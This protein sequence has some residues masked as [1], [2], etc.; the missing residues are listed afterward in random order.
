MIGY[1]V[2]ERFGCSWRM[3]HRCLLP[4]SSPHRCR[5]L[6]TSEA[7]QFVADS[8]A[9]LIRWSESFDIPGPTEWWYVIK[10]NSPTLAALDKKTRYA[11][12]Q[13]LKVV[14]ARP[15]TRA[16]IVDQAY[17]IYQAAYERYRTF[18]CILSEEAFRAAVTTM[19]ANVEFWGVFDRRTSEMIA[20]GEN[21][22]DGESCFY[23]T[24]WF[25]QAALSLNAAYVLVQAMNEHYL[26]DR[27]MNFVSDGARNISHQTNVHHFLE[28][29][30]G[31]RRAYADLRVVYSPPLNVAIALSYPLRKLCARLPGLARLAVLLEQERIHR[32]FRSVGK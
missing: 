23:S 29:K 31:F 16:Q 32:T 22:I 10:S 26:G 12:R 14:E 17:P 19:P 21:V 9:Y 3:L 5:P 1:Q 30:F 2:L 25:P 13:G 11:V 27:A 20:F 18:E 24:M 4:L 6:N 8:G 28:S 15:C 7:R